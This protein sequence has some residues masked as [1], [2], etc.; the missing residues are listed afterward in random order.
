MVIYLMNKGEQVLKKLWQLPELRH[1]FTVDCE[2]RGPFLIL[3]LQV[4]KESKHERVA[5]FKNLKV[6][7]K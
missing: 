3:N 7:E 6:S 2:L 5:V 1:L 4:N